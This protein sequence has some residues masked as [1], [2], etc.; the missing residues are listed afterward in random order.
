MSLE[1]FNVGEELD[2]VSSDGADGPGS[3]EPIT[4][5]HLPCPPPSNLLSRIV[6]GGITSFLM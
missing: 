1:V 3:L 5:I 2:D 6:D 4:A